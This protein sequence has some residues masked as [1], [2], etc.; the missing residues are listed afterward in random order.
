MGLISHIGILAFISGG[1]ICGFSASSSN[2][3]ERQYA[4]AAVDLDTMRIFRKNS[5]PSF[6]AL[7]FRFPGFMT[8]SLISADLLNS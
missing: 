1:T 7:L 3:S 5:I 8:K 2:V 4:T 6:V